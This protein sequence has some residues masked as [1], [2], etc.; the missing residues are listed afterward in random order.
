MLSLVAAGLV[1][2]VYCAKGEMCVDSIE[3]A[4]KAQQEKAEVS[5]LHLCVCMCWE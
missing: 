2:T 5:I 3:L 1:H 4:A